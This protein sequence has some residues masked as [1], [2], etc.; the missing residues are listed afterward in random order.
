[1]RISKKIIRKIGAAVLVGAL[2][3]SGNMSF[4]SSA[5]LA[6]SQDTVAPQA[7]AA[8]TDNDL[9]LWYNSM[10]GTNFSGDPYDINESFYKAL[11]LGNGRIGAMVYGNYPDERIDLNESTFWSSGPS[12]N[13]KSGAVNSLKTAQD[14]LFS[15]QYSTGSTTIAKNMIGGGE[16]RYQ[17]VGDLKL[18]FGH[19]SVSGYSR[20]L[21]MN[22][23]VVSCDYTYNGKN[24]HRESFVSYPDQVMVTKITCS[25]NGSVSFTAS[26]ESSL[27][28]Q[29]SVSAS[30]PDTLVMNGHGDSDNGVNYA[31]WFSTRS[32]I[33]NTN[34]T[35]SANNNQITV[36]N[37]DSVV[38]LTSVRTNFVNYKTCNG[39]EKGKA[40]ADITNASDKSYDTLYNNHVADY[41]NLFKR[42]DVDLGGSGSE[43]G[44]PMGQRISEFGTTNDPKM[45]KV[46]FQY[47]RYLMISASRDSQP[48]NLQGIWNKFRNPAWGCKLTTNINYEMNYW[49]ALT[50]NLA[51]CFKPFVEKAKALQ[52]PGNETARVHYNIS[53]GWV[54]HHNTDLWNRTAPIDGEW[55]FWP[56]G[57]GWVSNM[58]YD[59]Y[60]F[61]QDTAYLND[62]YPVIKGAADFL[63]TLMQSHSINGQNYQVICP[64]T[65]PEVTPPS[66]SGGQ[67]A[68]N[69][70]GVTMD[71]GISRELF[72]DVIQASRILN[73]D[74]TFSSTL[75]SKVSQ[76]KPDTVGSWGQLQE[77]AYDWDSQSEKNRHISFAYDLFPGLEINKRDTP[78]IANAVIK[79]LNSRG[80]VGTGWSEAWKLNCWARLE[81]GAHAYNMV[82]LLISPA[83]KDGRLYDNL[84]DAHPPFQID[85]NFGFT[86]GIAEMLLQSQNNEIQL[87]P[88]LPSQWA[89]GHANGL[90]ARGNFTVTEMNWSNGALTGATIKSNSG[91]ICNVRY[92][93]KTISFPTK[94]GDTYH[95]NSSLQLTET[96]TT[97]TNVAL[98]KTATASGSNTDEEA[99][100]AI[101]GSTTTQWCHDKGMSGEWL[102]V[103]L[104]KNYDIS[105]WVVKHAGVSEAIKFNTRDFTLQ[106]SDDGNTWT[107]VDVVYGNQQNI[108]DRNVPVFNARYVRLYVNT[109]TQDNSGGARINELELWG[110]NGGVTPE[111]V[112]AFTQIEA[113]SYSEQSGIQN[114]TCDEGTEA[115]GFTEN[116]DYAV[117]K[118]IDFG[119]GAA[120][121]QARVS[122]ATSGGNIE[123]RLDSIDGTLIGT[124]P[125]AGTGDWQ[126]FTDVKCSVSGAAGKHDLYL[127]FTGGSGY[128]FNF[129]WY[130]F[131]AENSVKLG[132]VN[133]DGQVDAIDLQL[134]KKYILGSGEIENTKAADLDSNGDVNALDFALLKQYLLGTITIFPGQGAV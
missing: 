79:S 101:D 92:G 50:T 80:D 107:D 12:N 96:G 37:A 67:G 13:N 114:V 110:S 131:S 3:V 59:A 38:I 26:Y 78:A 57:A 126:T 118:N 60:N 116:G 73:T 95:L 76:I 36:T 108:T 72:K 88:A 41:Q 106:K 130:K 109:A 23:G 70:Y 132:D 21:D 127:V 121:F 98:N 120:G 102:Q 125:V 44:K 32:K 16:A 2:V 4:G 122:S 6:A 9:K 86:S 28:G 29:Y 46:L 34:G 31:V 61:N 77:W 123:L 47:G 124:C 5:A 133:S 134:L 90:C 45:A 128:L 91:N 62:I 103:D 48:M 87:L 30:G 25:S 85:G 99:A 27:S 63:Q 17:S 22:T 74:S 100:K 81:D 105:R 14:Q 82:K 18:A 20:Q 129:N 66:S 58:L 65:S 115:V 56:T 119:S 11:P 40:A 71:N 64:G 51:E 89:T 83:N 39:D 111:P 7:L 69:S 35:V 15:G 24:Y 54:M 53:N 117:Y 94:A 8:T 52:A 1:M 97:L 19:S 112:S 42:V 113:E 49:P 43:N 75:Q 68:Y 55:G 33:L 104:G 93:S 84:W 10:A